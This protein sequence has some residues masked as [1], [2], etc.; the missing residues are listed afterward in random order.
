MTHISVLY[1]YYI[2]KVFCTRNVAYNRV[3]IA[4]VISWWRKCKQFHW[5]N[6]FVF[7]FAESPITNA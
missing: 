1:I 4:I 5:S 7:F 3:S 2:T 6:G